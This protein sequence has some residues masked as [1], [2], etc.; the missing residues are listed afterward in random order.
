M[1]LDLFK[2][3]FNDNHSGL[4]ASLI[5]AGILLWC[6][7]CQSKCKSLLDPAQKITR[8]E[9]KIEVDTLLATAKLRMEDLDQQDEL[10]L[11]LFQQAALFAETGTVNPLGILAT[12][13]SIFAVGF[14]L[15][16][17]RKVT[18]LQADLQKFQDANNQTNG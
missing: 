3:L 13:A 6:Y 14:G 16:Q 18:A 1:N 10:K 4:I 2:K 8:G 7:G 15:D 9:L 5:I 17:R 12:G 11:L